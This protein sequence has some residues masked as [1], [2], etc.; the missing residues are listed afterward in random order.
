MEMVAAICP[1]CHILLVE[2]NSP[3]ITDLGAAE[4]SAVKLG[5]KFIS[6]S[7]GGTGDVSDN[8]YF[9]H[10]GVA[11]SVAAGDYGY[12]G[13]YYPASSQLVTSVGGTTLLPAPGTERGW[14]ETA[15]EFTESGCAFNSATDAKPAWQTVDDNAAKG[16]LNRTENDVSAVA[17][18]NTPVWI[19]DSVYYGGQ[20][21]DWEPIGGTSVAAPI[22]ASVYALAGVPESGTY[23]ASYLYQPGHAA[24]LY[25][26]TSG[27]NGVCQ[28]AYLCNAADDYQ[29]TTYNG[30]TGWG[31]PDGTA[32]F[33]ST[34]SGDV[35]TVVDPGTQDADAGQVVRL[36]ISVVDS[37]SGQRLQFSA[38]GLPAGLIINPATGLISGRLPAAPG[39][40]KVTV[41]A[42]DG[43]G[44]T[45][46]VTFELVAIPS[47]RAAYHRVTGPVKLQ[48]NGTPKGDVCVYAAGDRSANGTK[49]EIWKCDRSAAE[50]W[51]YVP[52][53]APDSS[54]TLVF[55]G[56]CATIVGPR[57][58]QR[59]RL[60]PCSG[61]GTQGWSLQEG[62]F[63]LYNPASGLCMND[64][65]TST[66]NGTQLNVLA[67]G[68]ELNEAFTLPAGP[69]L[70]GVGGRCLDD[71]HNSKTAGVKLEAQPCDGSPAQLWSIF[72]EAY[73]VEVAPGITFP[74]LG[75]AH[76]GLCVEVNAS[77]KA[78]L[79]PGTPVLLDRCG[80]G[81]N[82]WFPLPDGQVVSG[83]PGGYSGDMCLD[84]MG[85]RAGAVVME[86]C[87]GYAGEI[88]GEG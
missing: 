12:S 73:Y 62:T 42:A 54:G 33:A 49:V 67:C 32:A 79:V 15:W 56:R 35:I 57:L 86:P 38:A 37:A 70:S 61:A 88:W 85:G 18:P 46:T 8:R 60:E 59:L 84:A 14:R 72:S 34:A 66:R 13:T 80:V 1:L 39:T 5:A 47:L 26:V 81:D 58:D 16:C 63:W 83:F 3:A 6:D 17:D 53:A 48:V 77:A 68:Y 43:T 65:R 20:K 22:I 82:N 19:Y 11:I 2:A 44:A 25:P 31:T 29:G 78:G 74:A 23:P 50:Q 30:P 52:D 45:G 41:T 76:N 4:D 75:P 24:D 28:P 21:V 87:Y 55:R 51:T 9:D 36:P 69:V 10:P 40:S 27:S 7:W 71:P 64:P